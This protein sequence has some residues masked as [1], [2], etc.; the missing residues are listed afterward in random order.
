MNFLSLAVRTKRTV[1]ETGIVALPLS[2][3][4]DYYLEERSK[5]VL[6]EPSY[7]NRRVT[8]QKNSLTALIDWC[9]ITV[10]DVDLFTVITD[11]LKIPLSL[12]ELQNKGKGIAGH[13]LV[14]GFDNIKI[15]K[16]TGKMQYNG[17]QILMSGSGCR[18]YENFLVIN[19]ETWFDF[20]ARVCQYHVNF[21]RIDLAIDD[22]KPYLNIPELIRL[23][24][25]GL[26]S[27]QLRNYSE[28]A[29][30]ELSESIP[31]HKGNTLYLGSSNS[32]FRIVFYEK[33]YEQ[34]EKFGKELDPNWNR[35]ELRFRQERANKVV[36]KLIARRDVAE[37][38]M[39]VLNGKI[40]FLE[41]PENKSTSRKR[42]YPTYPPW[43]LFMQDIEK[44]KLTIQPQKKTLNSIWNWLESSVAPSLKLFSEIGELDNCDYIQVLIE[45]AKMNDTQI[46]IY[47]DYKKSSKLPIIERSYSDNE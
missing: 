41:Q 10:K 30:G 4:E 20:F 43:E 23:T 8:R 37:I 42:L 34:A 25:Q 6:S 2:A 19:K 32:D 29:S 9:Q 14:A 18:N 31:V 12:M 26:I 5:S 44:I 40:R 24:K 11:I 7:T 17:F 27:S 38:A 28:N 33:G 46:K 13:E 45:Q 15:L 21:P 1:K 39:S 47:E 36:Q 16:P 22:H 3:K 35:Y